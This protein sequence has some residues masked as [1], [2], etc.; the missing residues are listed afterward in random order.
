MNWTAVSIVSGL[1][2]FLTGT[3]FTIIGKLILKAVIERMD[4]FELKLDN[5]VTENH[6]A[7]KELW[8]EFNTMRERVARLEK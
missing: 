7:H 1:A 3:L 2:I 6:Q 8:S 4:K 5:I